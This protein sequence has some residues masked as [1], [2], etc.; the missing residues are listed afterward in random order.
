MT[1]RIVNIPF[2]QGTMAP[3]GTLI[4]RARGSSL[5][6]EKLMMAGKAITQVFKNITAEVKRTGNLKLAGTLDAGY[7]EVRRFVE[8]LSSKKDSK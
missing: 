8:E 7:E 1:G 4:E 6:D 2:L 5:D 3:N